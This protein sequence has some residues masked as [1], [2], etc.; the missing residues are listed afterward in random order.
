MTQLTIISILYVHHYNPRLVH[1]LPHFEVHFIVF[2]A[3]FQKILSLCLVSIP[4]RFVINS[5][6]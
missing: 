3:F 1:F 2:K 5:G 4:D 6:L